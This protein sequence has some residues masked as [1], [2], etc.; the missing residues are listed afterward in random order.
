MAVFIYV[1]IIDNILYN[2]FIHINIL[3]NNYAYFSFALYFFGFLGL[4]NMI[5]TSCKDPGYIKNLQRY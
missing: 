2:L 5:V 1:W 4:Y 3:K